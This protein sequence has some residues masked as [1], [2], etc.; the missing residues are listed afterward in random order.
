M[1]S[2]RVFAPSTFGLAA[3][4]KKN[5]PKLRRFAPF[6]KRGAT[7]NYT[8]CVAYG[9]GRSHTVVLT[10]DM[11]WCPSAHLC[12]G[13]VQ[14]VPVVE[15]RLPAACVGVSSVPSALKSIKYQM[16][17]YFILNSRCGLPPAPIRAWVQNT[18]QIQQS[19]LPLYKGGT[20]L[21]FVIR[22]GYWPNLFRGVYVLVLVRPCACAVPVRGR[23]RVERLAAPGCHPTGL[24]ER[25]RERLPVCTPIISHSFVSL[26]NIFNILRN[27]GCPG[28]NNKAPPPGR[29]QEQAPKQ[30]CVFSSTTFTSVQFM[31]MEEHAC[32]SILPHIN[33]NVVRK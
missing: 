28:V 3:L 1:G 13:L 22:T 2:R 25:L 4:R 29:H 6:G 8:K 20:V 19:L 14:Q 17:H 7:F 16:A 31:C 26:S 27:V 18:S 15:S 32:E 23:P 10:T 12:G 30:R 33:G 11:L 9:P 5:R 21:S 24:P